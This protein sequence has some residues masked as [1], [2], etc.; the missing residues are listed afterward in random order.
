MFV[1]VKFREEDHR[2]Y[3]YQTED[4][5]LPGDC[6]V[7]EVRGEKKFVYVSEVNLPEPKFACKPIMGLAPP[8]EDAPKDAENE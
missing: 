1:S 8:K 7:V 3:T 4:E 2:A 6:V 5:Y